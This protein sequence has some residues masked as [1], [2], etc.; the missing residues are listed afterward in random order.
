V[1][2][3]PNHWGTY[4]TD[5]QALHGSLEV[6][7]LVK[8]MLDFTLCEHEKVGLIVNRK[9]GGQSAIDDPYFLLTIFY[10]AV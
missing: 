10:F 2:V 5:A 1:Q 4:L 7:G 9:G 6:T 8:G 3:P